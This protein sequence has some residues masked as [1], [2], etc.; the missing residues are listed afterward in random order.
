M[1]T[2]RSTAEVAVVDDHQRG[3]LKTSRSTAS[4]QSSMMI[5][6]PDLRYRFSMASLI[7]CW[8][9]PCMWSSTQT[10]R[11][12]APPQPRRR[13]GRRPSARRSTLEELVREPALRKPMISDRKHAFSTTKHPFFSKQNGLT[14]KG[15]RVDRGGE[16]GGRFGAIGRSDAAAVSAPRKSDA[17]KKEPLACLLWCLVSLTRNRRETRA[18]VETLQDALQ[19][20]KRIFRQNSS[21]FL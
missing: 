9:H 3:G 11:G 13:H 2:S 7:P 16:F 17:R 8:T 20:E 15:E 19:V 12:G 18:G 6:E 1:K 4:A 10:R 14:G 21:F 5:K